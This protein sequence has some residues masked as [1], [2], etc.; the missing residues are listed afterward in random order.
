MTLRHGWQSQI[1][2]KSPICAHLVLERL[3]PANRVFR[4][5]ISYLLLSR[6]LLP[7]TPDLR[8]ELPLIRLISGKNSDRQASCSHCS[9]ANAI[10]CATCVRVN[11]MDYYLAIADIF[12]SADK[13]RPMKL[14]STSASEGAT[15]RSARARDPDCRP[16]SRRTESLV[17]AQ[18]HASRQSSSMF[19]ISSRV[20]NS[21]FRL[22]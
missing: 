18:I 4:M 6:I 19:P 22:R 14:A 15:H 16:D 10:L 7:F 21:V 17:R 9:E 12:C 3:S 8:G 11:V 1:I 13:I 20:R 5:E 2:E